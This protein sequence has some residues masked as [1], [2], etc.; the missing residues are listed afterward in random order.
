MSAKD[1][2]SNDTAWYFGNISLK[3][4]EGL[5]LKYGE[6]GDYI[7]RESSYVSLQFE[8]KLEILFLPFADYCEGNFLTNKVILGCSSTFK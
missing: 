7:V 5:L 6:E 4:S 2:K 1:D 8:K 3:E